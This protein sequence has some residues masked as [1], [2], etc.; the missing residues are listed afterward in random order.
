MGT[1]LVMIL[2]GY[3][4]QARQL[5]AATLRIEG[6]AAA[7]SL[8]VIWNQQQALGSSEI[9]GIVPDYPEWAWQ[10]QILEDPELA[11]LQSAIGRLT[12]FPSKK[13]PKNGATKDDVPIQITI[14]FLTGG[15]GALTSVSS[16]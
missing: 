1:L 9:E 6:V 12:V 7:E 5:K 10:F 13:F 2:D 14:E 16:P 4:R 3:G 15:S 11:K 8:L